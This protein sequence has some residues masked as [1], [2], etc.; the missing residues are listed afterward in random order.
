ML[1]QRGIGMGLELD[2]ESG[3]LV[4]GDARTRTGNRTGMEMTQ[5]PSLFQVARDRVIADT[6]PI[7]HLLVGETRIH[8]INDLLA[9]VGGICFHPVVSLLRYPIAIGSKSSP[10]TSPL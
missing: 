5:L 8:G 4:G 3:M 7:G 1:L 2:D 9:E 10:F 6:E